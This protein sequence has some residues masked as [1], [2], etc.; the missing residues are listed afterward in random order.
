MAE[1]W[2]KDDKKQQESSEQEADRLL[3]G[4]RGRKVGMGIYRECELE[5]LSKREEAVHERLVLVG[6]CR[7]VGDCELTVSE[8]IEESGLTTE[9]RRAVRLLT[10]IGW[11]TRPPAGK[12]ITHA[13]IAAEMGLSRSAVTQVIGRATKRMREVA[14]ILEERLPSGWAMRLF[15]MEIG[16]NWPRRLIYCKRIRGTEGG[17]N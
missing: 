16:S 9:Q 8:L 13:M 5:R 17:R 14:P 2:G 3:R 1:L 15:R 10:G 12:R 4:C 6:D 11:R 7:I